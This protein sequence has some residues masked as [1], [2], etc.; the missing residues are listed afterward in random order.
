MKLFW[1]YYLGQKESCNVLG[2][3]QENFEGQA[4]IEA[5]EMRFQYCSTYFTS[6]RIA[7][8]PKMIFFL[9]V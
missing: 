9:N 1:R 4:M 7:V 6:Q 8:A 3:T 2:K 5:I